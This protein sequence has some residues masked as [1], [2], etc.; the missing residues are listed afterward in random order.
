MEK[1]HESH[2][3]ASFDGITAL[4]FRWHFFLVAVRFGSFWLVLKLS[5]SLLNADAGD[6]ELL[7]V[8]MYCSVFICLT[9]CI[10]NSVE[11]VAFRF[12]LHIFTRSTA[13]FIEKCILIRPTEVY[14]YLSLCSQYHNHTTQHAHTMRVRPYAYMSKHN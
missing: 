5:S 10:L 7:F 8:Q 6:S 4:D 13:F 12:N 11:C 14:V 2:L 3:F 9:M 1:L